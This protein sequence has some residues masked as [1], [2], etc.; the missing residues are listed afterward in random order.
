MS[1]EVTLASMIDEKAL[2]KPSRTATGKA[3]PRERSSRMRSKISTLA[4]TAMPIVSTSPA[5]PGSVNVAS[6]I[7]MMPRIVV[8]V[9]ARATTATA[10]A[11]K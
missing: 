2:P 10:P 3:T 1:S 8:I 6:S 11:Q 9:T 7:A 5:M 4:S